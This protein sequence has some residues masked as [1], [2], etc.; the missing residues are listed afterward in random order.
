MRKRKPEEQK[1]SG[2]EWI[3]KI[4]LNWEIGKLKFVSKIEN[5]FAFKSEDFVEHGVPIIRIGDVDGIDSDTKFLPQL[6]IEKYKR[7][8]ISTGDILIAM[9]GAT[10]GKVGRFNYHQPGLLNQRV[11]KISNKHLTHKGYL[12]HV[13]SSDRFDKYVKLQ[14]YGG[15][16]E[17]IS[18]SEISHFEL[19]LPPL[20]EQ[21]AIATF[22]DHKTQAIDQLIEKKQQLI[23][24]LK[25]K[26]QALITRAVTKGL[27]SNTPM[28]DSGIE[29]LG[30]IPAHWNLVKF[31]HSV[32]LITEKSDSADF[33]VALEN[34]ESWTGNY[35][36]TDS[37]YNP[38]G[39]SFKADDVLFGKLRPY[40]AKGYLVEK[41]GNAIGDFYVFRGKKYLPEYLKM[42]VLS[43]IFI[44]VVDSSTY[45]AKMPRA[46]WDF[47]GEM[48]L[49][50]PSIDEQKLI[51]DKVNKHIASAVIIRN[52]VEKQVEKLKEYRQSLISAV[53][54]GKIDVRNEGENVNQ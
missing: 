34:L 36:E 38:S 1:N 35:I 54:T 49:P 14:A 45:G 11:C 39:I 8:K 7:Y 4:P 44:D 17:N 25:E 41:P 51:I 20:S 37:N 15:A 32:S 42:I 12:W 9:S 47:I 52:R 28:K 23:E 6:Y 16:Q 30:E 13:L 3:G 5:G 53:V 19:S 50:V 43:E 22:L 48:K 21:K 2:V 40:L 31:K 27:N 24:K 18:H 46:S 33:I 10:V 29:W 26:R